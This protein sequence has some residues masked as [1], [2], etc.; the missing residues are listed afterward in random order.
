ML[1]QN[2]IFGIVSRILLVITIGIFM[3]ACSDNP[4]DIASDDESTGVSELTFISRPQTTKSLHF[5][6]HNM[7]QANNL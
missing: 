2:S 7:L 1:N 3:N 6:C 5:C 4:V